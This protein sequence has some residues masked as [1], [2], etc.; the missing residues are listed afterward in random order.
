MPVCV[1]VVVWRAAARMVVVVWGLT[2][3]EVP[4]CCS[5]VEDVFMINF[6]LCVDVVDDDDIDI[7]DDEDDDDDDDDVDDDDDDD[8]NDDDDNTED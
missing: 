5:F 2:G 3:T 7:D 4:R 6:V 8:D 1:T